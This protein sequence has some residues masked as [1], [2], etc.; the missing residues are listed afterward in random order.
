MKIY[1]VNLIDTD[2]EAVNELADRILYFF[3]SAMR[4]ISTSVIALMAFGLFNLLMQGQVIP[5]TDSTDLLMQFK[6]ITGYLIIGGSIV[7]LIAGSY[8]LWAAFVYFNKLPKEIRE[9]QV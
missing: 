5:K 4:F 9:S 7:G 8:M 3:G 1:Q 6:T 2:D